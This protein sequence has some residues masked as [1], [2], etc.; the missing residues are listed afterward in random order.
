ME[1]GYLVRGGELCYRNRIS[2]N[3]EAFDQLED[4]IFESFRSGGGEET[5]DPFLTPA[6]IDGRK[7]FQVANW[8]GVLSIGETRIEVL[9]K[10]ANGLEDGRRVILEMLR[11]TRA[12]NFK[13]FATHGFLPERMPLYEVF[14]RVFL[15]HALHVIKRGI[16]QDYV[17]REANRDCFKGRLLV[18]QNLRINRS[19]H[20]KVYTA[21][22]EFIKDRPANRLIRA[23]LD[24]VRRRSGMM[25]TQRLAR[26]L[27]FAFQDVPASRNIDADLRRLRVD[28][29]MMHYKPALSWARWLLKGQSPLDPK[30]ITDAPSLLFPM[31]KLF[32]DYVGCLLRRI[33]GVSALRL[34]ASRHW[35]LSS[36]QRF[37]M[38]PDYLFKLNEMQVLGDAKW[39]QVNQYAEDGKFGVS[40]SDLYQLYA[41]GHKYLGG[42]GHL[43]LFY[44][45]TSDFD[46]RQNLEFEPG[47]NLA[48]VPVPMPSGVVN[49]H[50]L[51]QR[52]ARQLQETMEE[53]T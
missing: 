42:K 1:Y 33:S 8:V 17:E 34:Q 20:H 47:L 46:Q 4:A 53:Q 52:F 23:A 25:A 11:L 13:Q 45:E 3:E 9:P 41:Y 38:R 31:E 29:M 35:L 36:P 27:T 24:L 40:Q 30:G 5:L 12:E 19:M 21:S 2:L 6:R 50:S 51:V 18:A 14:M 10:T 39:K 7:A 28:R 32:E 44:P 48:L 15:D 49:W 16:R 37:R 43:F 22:D 26:E